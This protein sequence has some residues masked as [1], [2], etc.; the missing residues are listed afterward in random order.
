MK[1]FAAGLFGCALLTTATAASAQERIAPDSVYRVSPVM[2]QN[3]DSVLFGQMWK[4]DHLLAKRDRS[5]I[6]IAALIASG[7]SDQLSGHI[8][9]GLD[10]GLKPA[11]IGEAINQ[12]AYYSGWPNAVS[13]AEVANRV[14][15]QRGIAPVQNSAGVRV[16]L[17]PKAEAARQRTVAETTA[18]FAPGLAEFTNSALF[19]DL[20][21][22]P[23]LAPRDRSLVTVAALIAMGQPEQLSFHL[24]YAMD[25][26]LTREQAGEV[27]SHLAFYA[28]FPRAYSAVPMLKRIFEARQN[29]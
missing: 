24:N 1:C 2:G 13:A 16:T 15:E 22:R 28:G 17:D 9:R 18:P 29:K 20:W 6:T 21:R 5:L 23:D 10:N 7:K 25:N 3:T 26:G 19:G 27:V 14:F 8:A 12:L 4:R 11:E